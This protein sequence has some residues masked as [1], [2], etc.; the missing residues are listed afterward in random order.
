AAPTAEGAD[1]ELEE[2]G[3]IEIQLVAADPDG[4]TLTYTIPS[5]PSHGQLNSTTNTTGL[6]TYTPDA[7]YYGE[8]EFSF[9]VSDGALTSEV[10]TIRL[11]VLSTNQPPVIISASFTMVEGST[12]DIVVQAS[13]ADDD[14]IVYSIVTETLNG[15]ISN[16]NTSTGELIYT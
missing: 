4:D 11:S 3:I 13:D 7:N 9:H 12:L 5:E 6:F 1:V 2:N 8:D 15:T 16:F 10:Q 14:N